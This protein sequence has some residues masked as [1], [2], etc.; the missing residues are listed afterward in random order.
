M[1]YYGF[2]SSS[3]NTQALQV[4][5][6]GNVRYDAIAHQGQRHGKLVQPQF[7]DI[8]PLAYR[9]DIGEEDRLDGAAF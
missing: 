3:G 9:K 1:P 2:I 4:H 8:V 6:E 5:G 7:K